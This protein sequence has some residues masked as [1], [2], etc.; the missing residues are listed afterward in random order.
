AGKGCT[1]QQ[2]TPATFGLQEN[3]LSSIKGDSAAENAGLL[4]G[5]LEGN[6]GPH[7]DIVLMNA[8][9][10]LWTTGRFNG[11]EDSYQAARISIDSGQARHAL[12]R[13]VEASQ[14]APKA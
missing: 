2:L 13:L 14:K 4:L 7:R 6:A 11:L 12:T 8:A 10:G 5:V 9:L 3:P 1:E